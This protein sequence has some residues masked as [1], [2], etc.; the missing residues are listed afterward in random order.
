MRYRLE[1][2][3]TVVS[4]AEYIA[5]YRDAERFLGYCRECDNYGRLWMCPPYGFDALGRIAG[6]G[7]VHIFGVKVVVDEA[8]RRLP[9]DA[10]QLRDISYS[11]IKEVREPFDGWLLELERRY[12]GSLAFFAGSCLLC[13]DEGCARAT[14]GGCLYPD[15]ARSS[16]EAYGFDISRTGSELLGI[17]LKWSEG[18]ALPEYFTLVSGLFTDYEIDDLVW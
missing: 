10:A 2:V 16:L 6:Y 11:I 9:A 4:A 8:V 13:G 12:H 18:L 15:R 5:R 1:K 17:E 3:H 14:G 7:R